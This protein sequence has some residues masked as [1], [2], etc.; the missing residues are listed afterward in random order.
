MKSIKGKPRPPQW[1]GDFLKKGLVFP[2]M[3]FSRIPGL[4]YTADEDDFSMLCLAVDQDF[5]IV[6]RNLKDFPEEGRYGAKIHSV[7]DF[8]KIEPAIG[9]IN[10]WASWSLGS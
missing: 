7:K 3:C 5:P 8:I 9:S 1:F 10:S 6:T 2:D 4:F